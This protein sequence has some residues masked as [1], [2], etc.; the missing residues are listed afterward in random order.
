V[1]IRFWFAAVVGTVAGLIVLA[2]FRYIE[3]QLP[4]EFYAHHMI[5]FTRDHVIGEEEV[6]KLIQDHG[7]TIANLSSRLSES[8][9]QFEYRM[10]IKVEAD[11]MRRRSPPTFGHGLR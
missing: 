3:R 7:F 5:R 10:T 2:L 9:K 11:K 8:G 4:S 6:H 1:G